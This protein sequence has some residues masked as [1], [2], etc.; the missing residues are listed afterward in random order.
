[1]NWPRLQVF[2]DPDHLWVVLGWCWGGAGVVLGWCWGGAGVVLVVV[3]GW[4]WWGSYYT[5]QPPPTRPDFSSSSFPPASP[6]QLLDDTEGCGITTIFGLWAMFWH[7][8]SPTVV[9]IPGSRA[10][11]EHSLNKG[12]CLRDRGTCRYGNLINSRRHR[13]L[14]KVASHACFQTLS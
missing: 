2:K 3:L 6:R 4:C 7:K 1:M 9:A 14:L 8:K 13:Y 5:S 10:G 11:R 12:H